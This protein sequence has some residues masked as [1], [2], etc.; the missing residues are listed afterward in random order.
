MTAFSTNSLHLQGLR[1]V[2]THADF[3]TCCLSKDSMNLDV[4]VIIVKKCCQ[5]GLTSGIHSLSHY[6]KGHLYKLRVHMTHYGL[7]NAL[8]ATLNPVAW[9]SRDAEFSYN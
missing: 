2:R 1:V 3:I 4:Y 5:G 9:I 7:H 8:Y 6:F